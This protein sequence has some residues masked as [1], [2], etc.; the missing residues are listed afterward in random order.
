[1]PS[2]ELPETLKEMESPVTAYAMG[3]VVQTYRGQPMVWHTGGL[4][5]MVSRVTFLPARKLAVVVLT[6]AESSAA[7]Q[8]ITNTILD[9]DL[10]APA[11]D[12]VETFR[13]LRDASRADIKE[14]VQKETG[15]RDPAA[16]PS[17][18]LASY[19][20]RYRDPWYGDV[21]VEQADGALTLRFSHSP[22][23]SGKLEHFQHDTYLTFAL[24]PDGTIATARMKAVSP[25]TDFSFDFHDL[26]LTPVKPGD[27]VQAW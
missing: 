11:K 20:G 19:A 5:G 6:N 12:W 18:P 4:P 8:S 25:S 15:H 7:F 1:M 3:E 24:N 23:L 26:L 27:P 17:L 22:A 2:G 21:L 16:T 9:R 14:A 13:V 10:G